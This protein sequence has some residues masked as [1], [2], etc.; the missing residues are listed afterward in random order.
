MINWIKELKIK[1]EYFDRY[2]CEI[3]YDGRIA[4]S[5]LRK[6]NE[7]ID[8]NEVEV[9][10]NHCTIVNNQLSE[11]K[12]KK[13]MIQSDLE[14]ILFG[15]IIVQ[16][17]NFEMKKIRDLSMMICSIIKH[18]FT[19]LFQPNHKIINLHKLHGV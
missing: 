13:L 18:N 16:F 4:E 10:K 9:Y 5:Q 15:T 19:T 2:R 14:K 12:R 3:C 17:T 11:F 1:R 6:G 8:M 7:N